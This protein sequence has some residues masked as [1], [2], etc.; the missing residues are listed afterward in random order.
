[1]G[2]Y[3]TTWARRLATRPSWHP[4]HRLPSFFFF[5]GTVQN[6]LTTCLAGG[7]DFGGIDF[8][9]LGG[10]AGMP[11][12]DEDDDS[13]DDEMPRLEGEED[14]AKAETAEDAKDA[15]EVVTSS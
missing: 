10:G 4:F 7:G 15:K 12:G 14:E 13:D 5:F 6:W 1:M 8:S 11:T 9:K 3:M 2:T